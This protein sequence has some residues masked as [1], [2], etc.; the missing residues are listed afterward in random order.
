MDVRKPLM[1]CGLALVLFS[2]GNK[3]ASSVFSDTGNSKLSACGTAIDNEFIVQYEDGHI[4][5]RKSKDDETFITEFI[6]PNLPIIKRVE[7]NRVLHLDNTESTAAISLPDWGQTITKAPDVWSQGVN[8]QGVVVGIVD[9]RVETTHPQLQNQF[10]VNTGEIP[11]NGIDDDHNG[12]IDDYYGYNFYTDNPLSGRIAEHGTH[13]AGIVVAEHSKGAI[14]GMAEGAKI[15]AAPFLNNEGSG[16]LDDALSALEYVRVRGVKVV[17]A[18]WGSG[19]CSGSQILA[20]KIQELANQG[21][22]VMV[23]AGN[24]GRDIEQYPESPAI[25]NAPNQITVGWSTPQEF[26][27]GFSNYSYKLVHLAAP[28]EDILSTVPSGTKYMDGTSMATPF[29]TAAAALLWSAKPN[30]SYA[31]VKQAILNS[32]DPGPFPVLTQGRL[33]VKKALEEIRRLAP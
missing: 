30:A 15:V 17:N 11:D 14:K 12:Y 23:A 22:L 2:C 1:A 28:G 25:L 31:Q 27:S 20:N 21:I 7:H 32:V 18:S 3:N 29:V 4:E 9:T 6:E 19:G 26:L 8:G 13:V 10:A 16:N 5:T 33:N 24:S